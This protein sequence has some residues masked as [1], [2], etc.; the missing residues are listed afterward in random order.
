[1]IELSLYALFLAKYKINRKCPVSYLYVYNTLTAVREGEK[2]W[3]PHAGI[4]LQLQTG[5]ASSKLH[6]SQFILRP[7]SPNSWLQH[8]RHHHLLIFRDAQFILLFKSWEVFWAPFFLE[9]SENQVTFLQNAC[10]PLLPGLMEVKEQPNNFYHRLQAEEKLTLSVYSWISSW[11]AE[12]EGRSQ[13][14][15]MSCP[16]AV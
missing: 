1:M 9:L 16:T 3:D 11:L 14:F 13:L 6:E 4:I 7:L 15:L 2:P 8:S 10:F 12:S 5:Q